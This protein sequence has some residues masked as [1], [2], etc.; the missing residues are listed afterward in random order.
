MIEK[1][2]DLFIHWKIAGLGVRTV[3]FDYLF[4]IKSMVRSFILT[5]R[6]RWEA[7]SSLPAWNPKTAT[8][9][10]PTSIKSV[11]WC[12]DDKHCDHNPWLHTS[13]NNSFF[14]IAIFNHQQTKKIEISKWKTWPRLLVIFNNYSKVC[15][16]SK[17]WSIN[18]A[19]S[20][21]INSVFLIFQSMLLA[22][23]DNT[24]PLIFVPFGSGTSKGYPFCL[25]VI[26]HKIARPTFEL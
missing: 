8:R 17:T 24:T 4:L 25:L 22:W 13:W 21:Q 11:V 23:S 14:R 3:Q 12:Q 1:Y 20:V 7:S 26:G 9:V 6:K 5:F 18:K 19:S 15:S 16:L 10:E 2:P